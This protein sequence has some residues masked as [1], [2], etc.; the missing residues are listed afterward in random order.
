MARGGPQSQI[1]NQSKWTMLY[2]RERSLWMVKACEALEATP[3]PLE[4]KACTV[5]DFSNLPP[6]GGGFQVEGPLRSSL[7]FS[8]LPA[9]QPLWPHCVP[10]P[11]CCPPSAIPTL[12]LVSLQAHTLTGLLAAV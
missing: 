5:W 3:H 10:A 12:T 6:R 4:P 7:S 8:L 11:V 1:P 9:Q 2:S